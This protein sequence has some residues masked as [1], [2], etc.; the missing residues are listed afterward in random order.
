MFGYIVRPFY[1]SDSFKKMDENSFL[2]NKKVEQ[3]GGEKQLC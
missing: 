2:K 1:N 3:E